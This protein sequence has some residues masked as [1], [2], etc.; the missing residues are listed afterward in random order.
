[1]YQVLYRKWRPGVF[2]DTVG[3]PHIVKTLLAQLQSGRLAHAYLFTGSRGT[4][5]TTVAKILA[6]AVNCERP[7]GGEPCNECP[8]CAGILDGS[9]PDVAE[10]DAASHSGVDNIR[11]L[12]EETVYPPVS[13]KYRVY[14]IDEAHMLSAGAFNALLKT[15]EEPP[16]HVLFILA[17]TETHKIPVTIASRCQR[18]AFRRIS[19]PEISVLLAK[20]CSQEQTKADQAALD[21][22]AHMADGSLR[23]ALSLLE[24]CVSAGSVVTE[25]SVRETLGLNSLEDIAQWL[26]GLEDLSFSLN[27]LQ[28]LYSSGLELSS[29]LGQLASVLRDLLMGQLK[30]DLLVTRLPLEIASALSEKWPRDR[31]VPAISQIQES[32][33]QLSRVADKHLEAELCLIRL[34]S[35]SPAQHNGSPAPAPQP[36]QRAEPAKRVPENAKPPEPAKHKDS[37]S[38]SKPA[39]L[40]AHADAKQDGRWAPFLASLGPFEKPAVM[41]SKA[42]VDGDTLILRTDDPYFQGIL[43]SAEFQSAVKA[44]FPGGLTGDSDPSPAPAGRSLDDFLREQNDLIVS[45]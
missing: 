32:I 26:M 41:A 39:R 21:L 14:I 9:I 4:G 19:V 34:A 33:G 20:I 30:G 5:K 23:D 22:L 15:L 3:Q 28:T 8:A 7:V 18:F 43:Q 42:E 27:H 45:E 38:P 10:I 36:I 2:R 16:P 24:Q 44:F 13:A 40:G 11:A 6:R 17:T 35:F 29:I 31:I 25:S 12:R 1:L 37:S